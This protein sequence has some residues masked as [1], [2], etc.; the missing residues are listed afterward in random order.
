MMWIVLVKRFVYT[1]IYKG[2]VR[3]GKDISAHSFERFSLEFEAIV[4]ERKLVCPWS[5]N[6]ESFN[7]FESRSLDSL[8]T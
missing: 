5:L 7:R 3:I 2:K 1:A 8:N 4:K 6:L